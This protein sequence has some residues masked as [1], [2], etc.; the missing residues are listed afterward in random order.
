M[1]GFKDNIPPIS[2]AI[3]H[4]R[5]V[6]EKY[7]ILYGCEMIDLPLVEEAALYFRTSGTD[8]DICNKELFEVR[9]YKGEF[10]DW[11]LRPEGTASCMRAIKEADLMQKSKFLRFAYYGSM[12]RYNRPQKG[13]YRQFLNAGWEFIGVEGAEIDCELIVG[14]KQ[15]LDE[16]GLKYSLEINSIG[17]ADDRKEYRQLL[18]QHFNAEGKDPLKIL[19]KAESF[20]DI[21]KMNLNLEAA[22][23]FDA[24]QN[25]LKLSGV[26]FMHNPYLIRGLDYYNC[27]VFEF[28]IDNQAVLAGGRYDKLMEQ[29]GGAYTPATGFGAGVD[30]IVNNVIYEHVNKHVAIIALD[31]N[32]Y[33][34][35]VATK[36]RSGAKLMMQNQPIEAEYEGCVIF[37]R[38]SLKKA[39]S[40]A[41]RQGY[42]YAIICGHDEASSNT[43]ILK[44]L[45]NHTQQI[46]TVA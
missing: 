44:D 30:R 20:E 31:A 5:K 33:A 34:Q 21:P 38:M 32:E 6:F 42:R 25:M 16:L 43:V 28:K 19:D 1:R 22:R 9:K 24:L 45:K 4:V 11:V 29:I 17:N 46:A 15:L 14:A 2:Y 40:E 3:N 35:N 7:S 18:A 13:R 10:E 12:F 26:E 37:W 39:L 23:E 8:S 36:L 27:T 41:D